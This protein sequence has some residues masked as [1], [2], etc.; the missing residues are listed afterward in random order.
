MSLST[1][2]SSISTDRDFGPNGVWRA[3]VASWRAKFA[4]TLAYAGTGA[5]AGWVVFP[6]FPLIIIGLI[7]R[8]A[9]PDLLGYLVIAATANTVSQNLTLYL[10]QLLD[11]ERMNGTLVGLFLA[12]SPRAAWLIGFTFGGIVDSLISAV[13]VLAVGLFAFHVRLDPNYLSLGVT[14]LLFLISIGGLGF[15]LTG[16][17]LLMRDGGTLSNL[18]FPIFAFLGGAWYPVSL[19]PIWLQVPARCLP[20]GYGMQALVGAALHYAGLAALASQL[21]PLAGFAVVLPLFGVWII[22]Y[23]ERRIRTSGELELY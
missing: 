16:V 9:R 7:Y 1:T 17:G 18:I 8:G 10:A 15:N 6:A 4:E 19:L 12:P 5:V 13:V 14:A 21:L 11:D 22:S 2:A 23:I 20:L 3:V